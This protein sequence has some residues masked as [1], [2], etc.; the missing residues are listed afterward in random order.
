[1]PAEVPCAACHERIPGLA[2]G[3]RC[4]ACHAKRVRRAN[5]LARRISLLTAVV[6]AVALRYVLTPGP[7]ARMV[8]AIG[9][10]GA[11][12]TVRVIVKRVAME[13]LPD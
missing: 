6:T 9:T 12:L 11:F 13:F 1:L 10:L 4:N 3:A 5:Q 8:F 2:W 7:D